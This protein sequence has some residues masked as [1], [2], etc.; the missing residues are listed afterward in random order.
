VRYSIE[1][2]NIRGEFFKKKVIV[3]VEGDDDVIF[4]NE[5][6]VKY[7][8]K[9]FRI[10]KVGGKKNLEKYENDILVKNAKIIVASDRDYTEFTNNAKSDPRIVKTYGYSIE[11]TMYC[12]KRINQAIM[13][14]SK[15][16]CEMS[17]KIEKWMK[18]FEKECR[19]LLVYDIANMIYNKGVSV[20][21]DSCYK[22]LEDNNSCNISKDKVMRKIYEIKDLFEKEEINEIK[23][24][25]RRSKKESRYL[26]KGHF[27]TASVINY[28]KEYLK[29]QGVKVKISGDTLF[30]NVKTCSINCEKKCE[31]MEYLRTNI[32]K[33]KEAPLMNLC[34]V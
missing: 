30:A 23:R 17:T 33:S 2:L 9:N 24:K 19:L 28:I 12:P 29:K 4:W 15:D 34:G 8:Y 1:A 25:I 14:C 16:K 22:Y 13:F 26:I 21:G 27:L 11:N 10:E 3:Y 32:S 7:G 31:D 5:L 20:F 18:K 6:F